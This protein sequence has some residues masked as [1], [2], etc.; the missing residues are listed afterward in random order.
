MRTINWITNPWDLTESESSAPAPLSGAPN[1]PLSDRAK[2]ILAKPASQRT[3]AEKNQLLRKLEGKDK[4][5]SGS[6]LQESRISSIPKSQGKS[7]SPQEMDML[8]DVVNKAQDITAEMLKGIREG[9]FHLTETALQQVAESNRASMQLTQAVLTQQKPQFLQIQRAN[10]AQPYPRQRNWLRNEWER[11]EEAKSKLLRRNKN[12]R[13]ISK[14]KGN[15]T[16]RVISVY[17]GPFDLIGHTGI[18]I[19]KKIDQKNYEMYNFYNAGGNTRYSNEA[20]DEKGVPLYSKENPEEVITLDRDAEA[21]H[22]YRRT[23]MNYLVITKENVLFTDWEIPDNVAIQLVEIIN[24]WNVGTRDYKDLGIPN[25]AQ[26]CQE[27]IAEAYRNV[28][29]NA[30]SAK[31]V[32]KVY[33]PSFFPRFNETLDK[34]AKEKGAIGTFRHYVNESGDLDVKNYADRFEEDGVYD[35]IPQLLSD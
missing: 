31:T 32:S 6:R 22:D 10:F 8:L 26:E 35:S 23:M 7:F 34:K 33:V 12:D 21:K 17:S 25:C 14:N 24:L 13:S 1:R 2:Q 29:V 9:D 11:G 18:A 16:L 28:G 15:Y 20:A 30:E 3:D 27:I 19:F 5:I 4:S